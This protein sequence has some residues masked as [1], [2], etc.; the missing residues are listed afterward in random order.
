MPESCF[1]INKLLV[2]KIKAFVFEVVRL[3]IYY[4]ESDLNFEILYFRDSKE[5]CLFKQK[6]LFDNKNLGKKY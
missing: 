5:K 2:F 6:K 1:L 3:N 4:Y